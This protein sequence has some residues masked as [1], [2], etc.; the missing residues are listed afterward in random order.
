MD[1]FFKYLNFAPMPLWL[2]MMF[3]PN[4]PL[5]ERLSRSSAIFGLGAFH[6][7]IAIIVAIRRGT[8][9]REVAGLAKNPDVM[10]LGGIQTFLSTPSGTLAAWAHMLALDLFTGGWIYRQAQRLHAPG[11]VR[12]GSL[13]FTLLSG[14]F[15]LLLFLLWR[16]FGANEGESL[17]E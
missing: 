1:A 3:A 7:V 10:S 17:S 12:I 15:G 6:Y 2:A 13:L 4:H 11:W 14:P 16:V 5:T 9:E 8:Q